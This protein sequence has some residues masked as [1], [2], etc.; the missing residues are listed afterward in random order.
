MNIL[1]T[2]VAKL[3]GQADAP[4]TLDQARATFGE[5][6]S[7]LDRISAL[8]TSAGLNLD[9]LLAKG[10][11]ALKDYVTELNNKVTTAEA[12]AVEAERNRAEAVAK[13][14]ES[15]VQVT[16]LSS[17]LSA[18][19]SVFSA[20]NFKPTTEN[21]AKVETFQAAWNA[22]VC[23]GVS[24]KMAELGVKASTLP[25]AALASDDSAEELRDQLA[26]A[27]TPEA[28]GKIAS[29]LNKLRDAEWAAA[30]GSN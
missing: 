24:Q 23:H 1:A 15:A 14:G 27:T 10:D 13:A 3:T 25:A 4:K 9:D 7:A 21:L 11:T 2:L 12:K 22:H 26:Q 29:K 19:G 16:A 18:F 20:I 30:S 5:A 6:K 8:F 28:R 17:Q